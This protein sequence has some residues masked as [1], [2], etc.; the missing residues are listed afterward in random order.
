[1]SRRLRFLAVGV[2]LVAGACGGGDPPGETSAQPAATVTAPSTTV[3]PAP[4]P[5]SAPATATGEELR[6]VAVRLTEVATLD[7]PVAMAQRPGHDPFFVAERAG[8]V[9]VV[10]DGGLR[11]EPLLE[12]E[13]TTESERGLLG[14]AFS[15]DGSHLY[16]SYT[17]LEGD[18]RLE[19]YAMGEGATEI[20]LASRRTLVRVDQPF[21]NHNGGHVAF[22]PDGLLYYGLGDG[23]GSGD[24]EGNAQ[25]TSTLLG[26]VL[27]ID[28]RAQGEAPYAIPADNPF[29]GGGGRGEIYLYGVRNPW[30]FSF[31]R[32]TGDLWLADVGQ[33]AIEE[34]N[35]LT[36]EAAAGAN[37]GWPALE[38]SRPYGGDPPPGAVPPIYEYTHDEGF[39]VTGGYVYRGEA[40]PAL[41]GAY[42]FADLGTARLWALAVDPGGAGAE[43]VDLGVGVD[44]GTL[45]SFFEDAG[46]ELYVISIAGTI[47]R[48]DPA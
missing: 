20:D 17:N 4:P 34:V 37:L 36:P 46:G 11:P 7:A 6:G 25:D 33:N 8:Q 30:R 14:L 39:S 24:P 43:R 42:V 19:E 47:S 12:V 22:G 10:E 29:A 3:P 18:S 1:M 16:V 21:S 23:G 31:D 2:A 9:R 15:P 26:A 38:G 41:G 28:P 32:A 13:T 27:R 45:V 44:E 40:I 5:P 48:L 35:R